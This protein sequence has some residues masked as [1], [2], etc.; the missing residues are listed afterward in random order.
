M[1][2]LLNFIALGCALQYNSINDATWS[3]QPR[4][5]RLPAYSPAVVYSNYGSR[6]VVNEA[7]C[8]RKEA[9]L[10]LM[11]NWECETAPEKCNHCLAFLIHL[12]CDIRHEIEDIQENII[13]L[14]DQ[15]KDERLIP[16]RIKIALTYFGDENNIQIPLTFSDPINDRADL[17]SEIRGKIV[18][19]ITPRRRANLTVAMQ[20][21]LDLFND[22]DYESNN[23]CESKTLYF[24]SNGHVQCGPCVCNSIVCPNFNETDFECWENTNKITLQELGSLKVEHKDVNM[25]FATP[26]DQDCISQS[27][28]KHPQPERDASGRD[29]GWWDRYDAKN[30]EDCYNDTNVRILANW[31]SDQLINDP[32][33]DCNTRNPWGQSQTKYPYNDQDQDTLCAR[34]KMRNQN[35]PGVSLPASLNGVQ[36]LSDANLN[37]NILSYF[38]TIS[39]SCS[40]SHTKLSTCHGNIAWPYPENDKAASGKGCDGPRGDV[41]PAGGYGPRGARGNPGPEGPDGAQGAPGYRGDA[42]NDGPRP[43]SWTKGLPGVK[44]QPGAPGQPGQPGNNG[45][46]GEPGEKGKPGV[47]GVPGPPG[48]PGCYGQVGQKGDMGQPGT[49]GPTGPQ[50]PTGDAGAPMDEQ[51]LEE[52]K[53]IL[54]QLIYDD[55]RADKDTDLLRTVSDML[56]SQYPIVCG[57]SSTCQT[58]RHFSYGRQIVEPICEAPI[59]APYRSRQRADEPEIRRMS[60]AAPA[61]CA[62]HNPAYPFPTQAPIATPFFEPIHIRR[63]DPQVVTNID[64]DKSS[65]YRYDSASDESW[66]DDSFSLSKRNTPK[67]TKRPKNRS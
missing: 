11:S 34:S 67:I 63:P 45:R 39:R 16:G 19:D 28:E 38:Q 37:N 29:K 50:G 57:K 26:N 30:T 53:A 64:N 12:G 10:T 62:C 2:L 13:G 9:D 35:L 25:I 42:G 61:E 22:H 18:P 15:L 6:A 14:V 36:R 1:K 56:R 5:R 48:P 40:G 66:S 59:A 23:Y 4:Q 55:I 3:R 8:E 41:G 52:Y 65:D 31:R 46:K 58:E 24:I 47:E 27:M 44:G 21:T 49:Q 7:T 43:N 51:F 33:L 60:M 54:R 17:H 32:N 20:E